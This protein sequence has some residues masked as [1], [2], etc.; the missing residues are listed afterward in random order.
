M[1]STIKNLSFLGISLNALAYLLYS[2]ADALFKY[3]GATYHATQIMF[4]TYVFACVPITLYLALSKAPSSL[5][6]KRPKWV[7]MRCLATMIGA[8]TYFYG[9]ST[10]SLAEVYVIFFVAPA[11]ITILAIPMLG[12][13]I[14]P[15]RTL[16]LLIGL[17]GVIIVLD[18]KNPSALSMGHV[19]ILVA[20]FCGAISAVI[21]RKVRNDENPLTM[22]VY[23]VL[24]VILVGLFIMPPHHVPMALVDTGILAITGIIFVVAGYLLYLSYTYAE[25]SKVAPIQYTQMVWAVLFSIYIFH[26]DTPQNVYYGLPFIVA[27][28]LLILYRESQT[29]S[30]KDVVTKTR[31]R[32]NIIIPLLRDK[33]A[34]DP[35]KTQQK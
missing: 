2:C 10:I 17:T 6:P 15:Y 21:M 19:A 16:A 29:D 1:S 32:S 34:K 11:M 30:N 14:G 23:P 31:W 7:F 8:P 22:T 35:H 26:E 24:S 12:E 27:S 20:T 28:G 25:A 5:Y 33:K 13:R 9:V 18:P 3:L 4:F